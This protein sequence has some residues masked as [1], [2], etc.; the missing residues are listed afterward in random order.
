MCLY[1]T[2]I[3]KNQYLLQY[4]PTENHGIC[5]YKYKVFSLNE[6]GEEVIYKEVKAD[7]WLT[8][9]M[10]PEE[11][12]TGAITFW[13]KVET[14]LNQPYILAEYG[15]KLSNS[16]QGKTDTSTEPDYDK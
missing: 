2:R 11:L 9:K 4:F 8:D 14:D 7:E 6:N 5:S 3:D 16:C 10:S 15:D 12:H 13:K 1:L